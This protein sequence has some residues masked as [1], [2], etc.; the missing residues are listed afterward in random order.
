MLPFRLGAP[1]PNHAVAKAEQLADATDLSPALLRRRPSQLSQGERQRVAI[2]RA[3]VTDPA[4]VLCDEPTGNLDPATAR[5]ILDLLFELS[6]D[7]R[8]PLIMVTHDHSLL[9]RFDR[10]FDIREL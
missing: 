4:V 10:T 2:C 9:D 5:Q 8:R 1:R 3:L 7:E 6:A